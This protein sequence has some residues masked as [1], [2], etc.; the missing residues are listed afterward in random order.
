MAHYPQQAVIAAYGNGGFR[1]ANGLCKGSLLSLPSGMYDWPPA[2][3]ARLTIADFARVA[4]ERV[5]F[6]IFLFGTGA[7]MVRPPAA[8]M[9]GF[10]HHGLT[11]D[12]MATGDAVRTYNILLG[13]GRRV[14]AAFLAVP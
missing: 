5:G 2:D 4:A 7:V 13:E 9:A 3:L 14:A 10:P 8:L 11:P 12:W 1:F 6:D